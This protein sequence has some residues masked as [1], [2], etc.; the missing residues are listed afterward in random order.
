MDSVVTARA[1]GYL[2]VHTVKNRLLSRLRRAR[3]PRYA[4]ALVLGGAYL[5]LVYGRPFSQS[6]TPTPGVDGS[7][8]MWV[9]IGTAFLLVMAGIAWFVPNGPSN[10]A[11]DKAESAFILPGP[12]SGRA[13]IGYKLLRAQ[14]AV[15]MTVL[16]WTVLMRRGSTSLALPLRAI[17]VWMF[18]TTTNLHRTGAEIVRAAWAIRGGGALR[19]HWIP[20][21][22]VI[23]TIIGLAISLGLSYNAI[24][25]GWHVGFRTMMVSISTAMASGPAVLVLW[26]I[27]AVLGPMIAASNAQWI[28]ALPAA[29]IVLAAHCAWVFRSDEA[30]VEAAI[31]RATE[32]MEMVR[33]RAVRPGGPAIGTRPKPD[34]VLKTMPLAPI[35]WPPT[36]IVW[37]NVLGM[38]RKTRSALRVLALASTVPIVIGVVATLDDGNVGAGVAIGAIGISALLLIMG[39]LMLRNDLRD[40]MLN[41]VSLKLMPLRGHAIVAAEVLSVVVPLAMVQCA[42]LGLGAVAMLFT[43]DRPVGPGETA[44]LLAGVI[45]A[46]LVFNAA[47]VSIQNAAPVLFPA[48]TKLGALTSGGMEA[49]G[50]MMIVVALVMLLLGAMVL[51]PA[52]I[53]IGIAFAGRGHLVTALAIG[54]LMGTAVLGVEVFGL[55]AV[56]GRALERT[57]P[58]DVTT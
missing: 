26:P 56:L 32:R 3:N 30:A 53:T 4:L 40:D 52:S 58:S 54:L 39:P 50:Q 25:A 43:H 28:S 51:V 38:R 16:I 49:L 6:R 47:F 9:I 45:P 23:A 5:V 12:V 57:E 13:L 11:L 20:T 27:H 46:V 2:T 37:K 35:G 19:K 1:F 7:S 55:I 36:A 17:G 34:S 31:T 42:L 33:A 10:L 44:V 48:W 29:L 18:F 8:T 21:G 24:L 22:V 14:L 41:I 15:V